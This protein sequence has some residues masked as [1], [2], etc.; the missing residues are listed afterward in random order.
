MRNWESSLVVDCLLL[1]QRTQIPFPAHTLSKLQLPV[2]QLGSKGTHKY[3][4]Y[5][6]TNTDILKINLKHT[7][8]A[9][10]RGACL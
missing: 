5:I 9:K 3:I 8:T 7:H 6:S 1:F 10:H 4:A 2:I